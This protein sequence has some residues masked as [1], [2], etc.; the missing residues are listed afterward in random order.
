ML[1]CFSA[2][3]REHFYTCSHYSHGLNITKRRIWTI[4]L[5]G[6]HPLTFKEGYINMICFMFDQ[7]RT[8]NSILL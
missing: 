4:I 6:Q 3:T 1:I 2:Q 5:R 8:H 7:C